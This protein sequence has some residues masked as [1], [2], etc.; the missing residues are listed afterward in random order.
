MPGRR[1]F[2]CNYRVASDE[3]NERSLG[4]LQ[5]YSCSVWVNNN[6][7]GF[8]DLRQQDLEMSTLSKKPSQRHE[9]QIMSWLRNEF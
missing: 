4:A 7:G 1:D 5:R 6:D 8:G 9:G 3:S 2:V